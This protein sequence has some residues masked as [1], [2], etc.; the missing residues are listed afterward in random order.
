M[1]TSQTTTTEHHPALAH[2]F[3]SM[4]QQQEAS[5]FGMWVFLLTEIMMFGGLFASY[6]IYRIKYYDAFVAGSTSIS[7][8]WG[9]ANTLVLIG[10]SFT[11]AMAVWAA[12]KGDRKWQIR[13]LILTMILGTVFLGIKG[14]E[15]YDKYEECHIPGRVIGKGFNATGGPGCEKGNIAKE[16]L[17]RS[18]RA[19]Q[20]GYKDVPEVTPES[21]KQIA[22]QTEIFFSYYFA[23]TGLHAFHM[24]IGLGLLTWL[25]L[26]ARAGEFGPAYYTPVELGGLYWHFVDIVWIF[27]FPL[28]Y[29]INRIHTG[30]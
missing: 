25:L 10:S 12:Q 1:S 6:L 15:Y 16:I 22:N 17:E 20:A 7:V 5:T 21:A 23:M 27:L 8:S 3:D 26:R 19:R 30:L 11:M 14:K 18:E 13:F 4:A 29:L 28:L 24:I 9:F 2:Q